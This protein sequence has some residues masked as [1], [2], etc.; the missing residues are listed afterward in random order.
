MSF[1]IDPVK[2]NGLGIR[3]AYDEDAAVIAFHGI[4]LWKIGI[5]WG[6]SCDTFNR[7]RSLGS[8]GGM[9]GVVIAQPT[10][11]Q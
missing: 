6:N 3:P 2:L 7:N 9:L 8:A 4:G 5:I 1:L 11:V 10:I